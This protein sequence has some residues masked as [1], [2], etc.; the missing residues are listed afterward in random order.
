MKIKLIPFQEI[1]IDNLVK[2]GNN[3][4]IAKHLTNA[5]PSPYTR[6]NATDFIQRVSE[7][8]PRNILAISVDGE[9]VGG[10]GLHPKQDVYVKN[11][12]L[13]YWL[14]EDYWNKGILTEVL[15]KMMEYGFENFDI[16]RLEASVFEFNIGSKRVLEKSGFQFEGR[17]K[18]SVFKNGKFYDELFF[19]Y[20][21]S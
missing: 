19:G 14:S 16:H 3:P 2:H 12:E 10:I 13:G 11:M 15:P 18:Q 8:N 6:Q 5:F 9:V 1:H 17:K 21:K 7:S 4:N 20:L